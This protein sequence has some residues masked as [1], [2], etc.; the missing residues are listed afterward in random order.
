MTG[1]FYDDA[2]VHAIYRVRSHSRACHD[3]GTR[4]FLIR[5]ERRMMALLLAA[6]S[7]GE[8]GHPGALLSEEACSD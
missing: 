1:H 3:L 4:A 2:M 7:G 5:V 6:Q 8:A